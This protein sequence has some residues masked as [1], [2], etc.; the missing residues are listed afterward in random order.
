MSGVNRL[1]AAEQLANGG[2]PTQAY[3]PDSIRAEATEGKE[4]E[5]TEV[6]NRKDSA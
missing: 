1:I 3:S 6:E 5:S 4:D 2:D